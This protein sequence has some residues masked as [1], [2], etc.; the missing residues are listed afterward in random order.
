M[1]LIDTHAH[2]CDERYSDDLEGLLSRAREAG[3]TRLI[4]AAATMEESD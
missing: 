2:I 3:L 4:I 1:A